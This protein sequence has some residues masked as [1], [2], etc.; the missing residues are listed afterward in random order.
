MVRLKDTKLK[1]CFIFICCLFHRANRTTANA[2]AAAT[3][4]DT[5]SVDEF[6]AMNS[7][8]FEVKEDDDDDEEVDDADDAPVSC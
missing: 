6:D 4:L 1:K 8:T 2:A 7:V 5:R 3:K